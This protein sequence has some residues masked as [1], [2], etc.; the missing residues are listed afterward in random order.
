VNQGDIL[1][2]EDDRKIS[3]LVG[4][5]LQREGFRTKFAH[6][7]AI[8]LEMLKTLTPQLVILDLMLPTVDGWQVCQKLRERSSVPILILTARGEEAERVLGLTLG[9]DDYVVKPF[10]PRELVERVK[11]I[12][13]RVKRDRV[14]LEEELLQSGELRVDQTKRI[15]THKG[16][17]IALTP[18]EYRI[19][20]ELMAA[21]GRVFSREQLLRCLY[22]TGEE[23]VQRVVDVHVGKLRQKL[24]PDDAGMDLIQ[25]VRGI[26]YRFVEER[27]E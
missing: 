18:S 19:L 13:R 1:V 2:V 8:A 14:G 6:D 16:A 7:G 11:A 10:S 9:A 27:N 26:G 3:S 20:T 5:Y 15:V 21:P 24:D 12:L 25:T 22:P 4:I 17:P 23:V